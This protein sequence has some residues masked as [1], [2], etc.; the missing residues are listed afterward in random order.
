MPP[1]SGFP[2]FWY[3]VKGLKVNNWLDR[4]RDFAGTLLIPI[5]GTG[6][7]S[8]AKIY[9]EQC[10]KPV[11]CNGK[12]TSSHQALTPVIMAQSQIIPLP[13]TFIEP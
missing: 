1:E 5:D 4:Q 7:F 11:H 3:L 10:S 9:C 12:V 2:M 8:S 13:P 6:Y